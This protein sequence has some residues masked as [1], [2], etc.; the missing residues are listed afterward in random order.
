MHTFTV[1]PGGRILWCLRRRVSDVRCVLYV[2]S[3]AADVQILQERDP[4]L[5]ERFPNEASALRWA[6]EYRDRLLQQGWR[7]SP[8][9]CS[10]SSAA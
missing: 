2:G 4:V 3:A 6:E 7:R 5:T 1:D 10:P 9:D 8:Q